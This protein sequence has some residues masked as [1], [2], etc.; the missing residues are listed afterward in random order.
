MSSSSPLSISTAVGTGDA[1]YSGDGGPADAAMMREPFMCASTLRATC[2]CAR[3]RITLYAGLT[4][5]LASLCHCRRHWQPGILRG[6]RA[7]DQGHDV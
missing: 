5:P 1:G 6:R 3:Q 4:P 7:R 2:T